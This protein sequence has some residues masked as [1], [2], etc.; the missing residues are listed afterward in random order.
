MIKVARPENYRDIIRI[1]NQAV[2]TGIQTAD[3]DRVSVDEK[4]AW[5]DL[6]TGEHYV[7]YVILK[8]E[9]VA[10]YLALSPYRHGRSAFYNTVE[11]S[12]YLDTQ[13]QGRG[14]G[15]Q[16]LEH[17]IA[18]CP[19]LHIETLLAILLSCNTAS[20][21]LLEKFGFQLWGSMPG[22]GKLKSGKVDHLYYGRNLA[23]V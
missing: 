13:Y 18:H 11:L 17:A 23:V 3:A 19:A 4:E 9:L 6:H 15:T 7:I 2:D 16:L 8:D 5:L 10:G 12:Y 1:Y 21:N 14:L 22:I 20:I